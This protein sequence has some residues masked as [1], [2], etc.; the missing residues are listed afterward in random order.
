MKWWKKTIGTKIDKRTKGQRVIVAKK[1]LKVYGTKSTNKLYKW[2]SVLNTE[3]SGRFV[4]SPEPNQHNERIYAESLDDIP[5]EL[6]TK[7]KQK[8]QKSVML[9]GG[10]SS[11]GLFPKQSPIFVDEWLEQIRPSDTDR[12]KKIYLTGERYAQFIRTIVAKAAAKEFDD[13][14][15]V[16]FRDDQDNKQR[17]SVALEAVQY[18]F[19]NRIAPS[20]CAAK[21]ADV[22]P[23]ENVWGALKEKLRGR[24]YRNFEQLKNHIKKEW[25]KFDASFC[26]QLMEKIPA[27]LKLL[28]DQN[29]NQICQH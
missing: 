21:L 4:L 6:K 5:Y 19:P 3:F 17:M 18:V 13:L 28:V 10:I 11:C 12:R 15:N 22:W 26:E 25:K 29:A 2:S 8:F 27:R 7:S 20:D 14:Q 1:L 23:I 24:E 9:W 16:I